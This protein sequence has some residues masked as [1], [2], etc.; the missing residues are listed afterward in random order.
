MSLKTL[1]IFSQKMDSLN[2][3]NRDGLEALARKWSENLPSQHECP[4][5]GQM[6]LQ[7]FLDRGNMECLNEDSHHN[8]RSLFEQQGH[9]QS[10]CDEQLMVSFLKV[11]D[12][13]KLF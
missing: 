13:L 7:T 5:H 2:G 11:M 4:V 8:I 6:D 1:Y 9:L 12:E 10:D 3:A